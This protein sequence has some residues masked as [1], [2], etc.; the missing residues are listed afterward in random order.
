MER[1]D[2]HLHEVEKKE[3]ALERLI[4]WHDLSIKTIKQE[5][6]WLKLQAEDFDGY[7]FTE[8]ITEFLKDEIC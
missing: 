1:L 5:I 6:E 4:E 8:E 2:A 3:L 7:D